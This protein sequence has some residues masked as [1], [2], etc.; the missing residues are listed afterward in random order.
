MLK[1]FSPGRQWMSLDARGSERAKQTLRDLVTTLSDT[2]AAILPFI[3]CPRFTNH[4]T[5]TTTP[6]PSP[7]VAPST[8][9]ASYIFLEPAAHA[10]TPPQ[11]VD[12]AVTQRYYPAQGCWTP[13]PRN[14]SSHQHLIRPQQRGLTPITTEVLLH[15]QSSAWMS[16][17][18]TAPAEALASLHPHSDSYSSFQLPLLSS[19][20]KSC[21][22]SAL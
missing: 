4:R 2:A 11:Y 14:Q 5:P 18:L 8:D 6:L 21:R 3:N 15:F 1:E 19:P 9:S 22:L 13:S 17:C 10:V 12:D 16:P 20:A 7:N